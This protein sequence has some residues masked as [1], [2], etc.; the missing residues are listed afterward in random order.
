MVFCPL[1]FFFLFLFAP[2]VRLSTLFFG[3]NRWKKFRGECII[4]SSRLIHEIMFGA[5]IG[6]IIEVKRNIWKRAVHR[7]VH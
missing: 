2:L 6:L 3:G 1:C 7:Y 5:I 4:F